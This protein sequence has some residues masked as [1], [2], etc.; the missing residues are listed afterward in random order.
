MGPVEGADAEG[1]IPCPMEGPCCQARFDYDGENDSDLTFEEDDLIRLLERVGADWMKGELNGK[2]GIFPLS[3]V[4]L[5]EDLP[6]EPIVVPAR[7]KD[8]MEVTA[9]FDFAGQG[10]ELSFE[11]DNFFFLDFMYNILFLRCVRLFSESMYF[12]LVCI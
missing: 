5:I 7:D 1:R 4:E 9:M 8:S 3:F 2:T 10:D 11:V 12:E 6:P